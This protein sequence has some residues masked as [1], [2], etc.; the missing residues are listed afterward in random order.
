[1]KLCELKRLKEAP[2]QGMMLAYTRKKVIFHSYSNLMEV[3]SLIG[4]MEL[5]ELHLFDKGREYRCIASRSPRYCD[6]MI[7]AVIDFPEEDEEHVYKEKVRLQKGMG[8]EKI[9]VL[10]HLSYSEDNGML[11]VDN[12]RLR[13]EEEADA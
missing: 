13:M 3:E 12:Y 1:M 8:A 10:N 4:E 6:G 5:L 9:V 11:M 7:E 2:E